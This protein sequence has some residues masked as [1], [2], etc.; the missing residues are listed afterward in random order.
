[1]NCVLENFQFVGPPTITTIPEPRTKYTAYAI[2][3]KTPD[4]LIHLAS[5]T[6]VKAKCFVKNVDENSQNDFMCGPSIV[7]VRDGEKKIYVP[8]K[9]LYDDVYVRMMTFHGDDDVEMLQNNY[10][11]SIRNLTLIFTGLIKLFK[12]FS[13]GKLLMFLLFACHTICST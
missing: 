11:F 4:T 3:W 7:S 10:I 13:N 9:F 8:V 1:M 5:R 2:Q 12:T 6:Y